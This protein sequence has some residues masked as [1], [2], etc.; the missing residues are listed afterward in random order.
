M[1]AD[2]GGPAATD[3]GTWADYHSGVSTATRAAVGPAA[4]AGVHVRAE[5]PPGG[6]FGKG[7][8]AIAAVVAP[9]TH[10]STAREIPLARVAPYP[11][12]ADPEYAAMEMLT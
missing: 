1:T 3:C 12:D 7:G 5:V 11:L 6:E 2:Q 4:R 10:V 8:Q 9:S